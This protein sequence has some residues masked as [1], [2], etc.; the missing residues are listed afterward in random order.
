MEASPF[1]YL[2]IIF[3][4]AFLS[5]KITRLIHIPEVTGYVLIGVVMGVSLLHILGP[6]VLESLSAVSTIALGLI[7]FI[8]GVELRLDI[9]KKLGKSILLIV[10]LECSSAFAVV[11]FVLSYFFPQYPYMALLLG[12][13]ASA[14]AP[15]ATVA[16]IKQYRA[17]GDLTSTIMA[18]VG[19]DD[20]MALII[21]VFASGIAKAGLTGEETHMGLIIGRTLLSIAESVTLGLLAAWIFKF[22]LGRSRDN[23]FI[24]LLMAAIILALLGISDLLGNSELLAVM[25]FGSIVVNIAPSLAKRGTLIIENYSP[26]F[27][28][29][30]FLLGGAHLDIRALKQVGIMGLF[31]FA[32]RTTGKIGGGS[33]GGILGR[34]PKK[35]RRYIGFTL[36]PQVGVALALALSINKEFTQPIYGAQGAGMA[37]YIINILLFTTIVTEIVGPLLTRLALKKAGEISLDTES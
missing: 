34:A 33:L 19:I 36:L 15:A 5:K 26:L 9:I 24:L 1:I 21:Y 31:Y 12:S 20:A 18:V 3:F 13:V 2:A 22:L 32:A 10:L 28:A 27:L 7:A 4:A 29:A 6:S 37:H 8:I 17:K 16:V 35:V 23:E 14:T 25:A 30:F 11:Y